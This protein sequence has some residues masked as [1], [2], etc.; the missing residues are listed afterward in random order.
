MARPLAVLIQSSSGAGKTTLQDATLR[1]MPAEQQVRSVGH[2][3]P[4]ALLHGPH[5]DCNTR[6]W[7]W[8]KSK[9][10]PKPLMP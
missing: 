10:W 8:P 1:F 7:R 9:A 5:G 3:R 4:V 6:F 2:D